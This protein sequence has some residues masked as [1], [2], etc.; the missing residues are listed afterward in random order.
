MTIP[1]SRPTHDL[2][3]QLSAM[4]SDTKIGMT[5]RGDI[6]KYGG[7]DFRFHPKQNMRVRT[8]ILNRELSPKRLPSAW[9]RFAA[10]IRAV[11]SG[12]K[13]SRLLRAL[14]TRAVQSVGRYSVR[15]DPIG[16]ASPPVRPVKIES[17][18]N[19]D[20]LIDRAQAKLAAYRA[21]TALNQIAA[22][23]NADTLVRG[24][25]QRNAHN[26]AAPSTASLPSSRPPAQ[27]SI[28]VPPPNLIPPKPPTS[29]HVVTHITNR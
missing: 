18:A 8:F 4:P 27:P 21:R 17:P 25:V 14:N 22:P 15:G 6:V 23:K 29:A 5:K 10:Q 20:Q 2:L 28:G 12:V 9:N 26:A 13:A 3:M 11:F 16:P 19:D 7:C 1:L 24:S